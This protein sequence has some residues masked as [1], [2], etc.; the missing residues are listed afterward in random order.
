M[1]STTLVLLLSL[2]VAVQ[3]HAVKSVTVEQL[4]GEVGSFGKKSD[5]KAAERLYDLQLTERLSANKLAGFEAT[6]PGPES[7][8]ALVALADQAEFLDP[9]PAEIP[10]QPAPSVAQQREIIARSIDSV[11]DTLNRLPN[12]FANRDTIRFEDVPPGL[13]DESTDTMVPYQ[14]L[15]PVSRSMETLLYR[16]GQEEI[17]KQAA[18]PSGSNPVPFGMVTSGEFGPI[19]PVVYGDLPKGNLRWSHWEQGE[20]GPES[21][22][23]FDV[24]KAASHYRVEFCCIRGQLFQEFRAY[25]G[26]L[27][28]EPANGTILRM[29]LIADP[30]KGSEIAEAELM[31]QYG[32]VELGGKKYFCPVR[33]IS[34]SRAPGEIE[35]IAPVHQRILSMSQATSPNEAGE[36]APLQTMLNEA[37]FENYHLFRADAQILSASNS[38]A[39]SIPNAPADASSKSLKSPSATLTPPANDTS[40]SAAPA[41]RIEGAAAESTV[42]TESAAPATTQLSAA[43]AEPSATPAPS[44]SGAVG[45]G[46]TPG[47]VEAKSATSGMATSQPTAPPSMSTKPEIA[48]AAPEPFP[49]KTGHLPAASSFSL[50]V[51]VRLVDVDVSAFDSR[52]RPAAGLSMEDFE[53]YDNGRKERLRSFTKVGAAPATP[54]PAIT[55]AF[56]VLYSNRPDAN[57][58]AQSATISSLG[59]STILLLDPTNLSFADLTH[60]REQILKFLDRVPQSEPVGIYVRTGSSFNILNEETTNHPAL[61]S[62]LGKW[63]PSAQDLARA[64]EAEV[65]NRQQFD[66][67]DSPCDIQYVNGNMGGTP[68]INSASATPWCPD[69]PGGGTSSTVDPKMMKEGSDPARESMAALVAIAAH[70]NSIPGHKDLVWV[71]SDNALANWTDQAAGNDKG[72]NTIGRLAIPTQEVLNDAHVSLY[73]LDASQLTSLAT[74]ASLENNSV[75]LNPAIQGLDEKADLEAHEASMTDGRAAAQMRQDLHAV[76]PAIQQLAQATGGRSFPRADNIIGDLSSVVQDGH[77]SYLLSF[78]PDTQPDGKYHQITVTVPAQ[79]GIKLRYRTGYLYS[80]EPSTLKDRLTQAVWQPQDESEIGL[81]AHWDHASQG[82]AISLNIVGSDIGLAQ[83]GD[84]WTDK[85]DIFLVQRD[86]TTTRAQAKEQTLALNLKPETYQKVLHDGIPFAEYVDHEQN[87]GTTRIIVV[88]ENSGRMGSV[89]LPVMVERASQ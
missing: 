61:I 35:R 69:I 53:V 34:V 78:S 85:L 74:D 66:T 23:R 55:S 75:Q 5:A 72:P 10:N 81:S 88:D 43:T 21:V 36:G 84:L 87:F 82:A 26:E 58:P 60:A 17:Q 9:P 45:F 48:I 52:G 31:V 13:R 30:E 56:P 2:P 8:R 70:I 65:R 42:K 12:L 46:E 68:T 54:Q 25:H 86:D 3:A 89:T 14:P 50:S 47:P 1:R 6:L 59:S 64:Q 79:L 15:H 19:F 18:Q 51:S 38:G 40:G 11:R 28:L 49:E 32:P 16:D 24:P 39:E 80:K 77:A 33:S 71:A 7:R 37:T 62:A 41:A 20:N 76:Q 63:I 57:G 27:T 67:V 73:P 83:E 44:T 22:F 4:R 29:T